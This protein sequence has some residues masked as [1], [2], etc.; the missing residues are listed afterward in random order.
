VRRLFYL[1]TISGGGC[2]GNMNLTFTVKS[3]GSDDARQLEESIRKQLNFPGAGRLTIEVSKKLDDVKI[4]GPEDLL[5][6]AR[7][8][9]GLPQPGPA[10]SRL[11]ARSKKLEPAAS[12]Y[13][14][15]ASK[16]KISS[17]KDSKISRY[18]KKPKQ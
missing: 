11:A 5:A 7:E 15:P 3:D 9:L 2:S 8:K 13:L 16:K 10:K 12:R 6:L 17:A 4:S 1:P 14:H 18:S